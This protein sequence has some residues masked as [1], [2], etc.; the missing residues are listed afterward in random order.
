L[1]HSVQDASRLK[2]GDRRTISQQM[3]YV[4]LDSD[5]TARHLH[6]APYLDYRPL[7]PDEPAALAIT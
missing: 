3:L 6:Y 4:E 5:G 2:N 7:R 1:E